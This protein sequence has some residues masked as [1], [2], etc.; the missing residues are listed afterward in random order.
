MM[1]QSNY[2]Y[3]TELIGVT[4]FVV[5]ILAMTLA[6][7]AIG[8]SVLFILSVRER[9][10]TRQAARK[11]LQREAEVYAIVS[12]THGVFVREMNPS[13]AWRPLHLNPTT[14]QNG[15]QAEVSAAELAAWQTWTLRHRPHPIKPVE[16]HLLSAPPQIDLLAV[17]DAVQRCLIVGASD[18]GKTTLL[19]H[20]VRR[21]L[22]LSKVVVIDPHAYPDKW[23]GCVVVGTGRNYAEIDRALTALV[24]LMT[25]RYD[26]IGKGAVG[27]GHHPRLTILIDEWRAIVHNVK[28]AGEAIK[29]LL[30]ESRKAAM[31]VF[32]ASHSDRAKPLGLAGEYDLKDGFAIVRLFIVNGQ[33]QATLDTGT[34]EV[35]ALL[36]GPY[37]GQILL[38]AS[39]DDSDPDEP[40]LLEVEPDATEA[41]ILNLHAQ[42]QS[43]SAIAETVFGS[44]GGHQNQRV[45]EVLVKFER[46]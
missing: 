21:R 6:L 43:I 11:Q 40:M 32:V 24:R 18:S 41:T 4:R 46:V 7:T 29:A 16:P 8:L 26:D 35:P 34:G 31:S 23:A 25:K 20:L 9:V 28:T 22:H 10:L 38:E 19:Q 5:Y 3:V 2:A 39:A 13:A 37:A 12:E 44:K 33:R 17:L 45:K 15:L 14:Y 1:S 30:T 27:E 36:P 42:G